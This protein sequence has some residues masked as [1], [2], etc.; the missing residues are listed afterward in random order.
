MQGGQVLHITLWS[1]PFGHLA[2]VVLSPLQEDGVQLAVE[3]GWLFEEPVA[4][5]PLETVPCILVKHGLEVLMI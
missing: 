1:R 3:G 5:V 4:K 2:L